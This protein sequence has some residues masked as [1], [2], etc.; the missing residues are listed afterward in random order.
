MDLKDYLRS[1]E[2]PVPDANSKVAFI[3]LEYASEMYNFS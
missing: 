1:L 3:N 2:D